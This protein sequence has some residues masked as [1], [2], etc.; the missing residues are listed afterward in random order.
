M[1]NNLDCY[2]DCL[3]QQRFEDIN[4]ILYQKSRGEGF[5]YVESI[6]CCR[7][8]QNNQ[9]SPNLTNEMVHF[10]TYAPLSI[11]DLRLPDN[12]ITRHAL[13]RLID[14]TFSEVTFSQQESSLWRGLAL[15]FFY[16]TNVLALGVMDQLSFSK[17]ES[18]QLL[19]ALP[20]KKEWGSYFRLFELLHRLK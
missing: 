12:E 10:L 19:R 15:Y 5:G 11:A 13:Y 6:I 16:Q 20:N 1:D 4:Q 14:Q 2:S 8:Y 17:N 3:S 18:F 7:L 9:L